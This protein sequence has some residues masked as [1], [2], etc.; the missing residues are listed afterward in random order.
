LFRS[1]ADAIVNERGNVLEVQGGYDGENKN[2]A[3]AK[4]N[5]EVHQQWDIVYA[6]EYPEEPKKGEL[7]P[8]FG[9]YVERDFYIVS[10]MSANRYLDLIGNNM[11]IKTANSR[12]S[13]IWYFDQKSYT[14]KSR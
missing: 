8:D 2:I 10:Q 4:P 1:K 9:L 14:I 13:Q 5:G 12:K 3:I 11:V 6:D 7:N